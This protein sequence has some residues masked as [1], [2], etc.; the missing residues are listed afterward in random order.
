MASS[1]IP[2]SIQD[3]DRP[4]ARSSK[5]SKGKAVARE[6]PSWKRK[7]LHRPLDKNS[8]PP[9]TAGNTMAK[10]PRSDASLKRK[11]KVLNV[12]LPVTSKRRMLSSKDDDRLRKAK[13]TLTG[14]P[15]AVSIA[16]LSVYRR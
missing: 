1:S 14:G 5:A 16:P 6:E 12:L 9:P 4:A 3:L 7:K 13:V 15:P 2:P 10:P 8:T 11:L